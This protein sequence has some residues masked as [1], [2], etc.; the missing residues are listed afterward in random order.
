MNLSLKNYPKYN[1]SIVFLPIVF[2]VV[3]TILFIPLYVAVFKSQTKKKLLFLAL[4]DQ[5]MSL[6]KTTS[7]VDLIT[8]YT[9]NSISGSF[10]V[11]ATIPN[12]LKF[13]VLNA[14]NQDITIGYTLSND[15][16]KPSIIHF[17]NTANNNIKLQ[18]TNTS[19]DNNVTRIEINY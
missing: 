19:D 1:E 9:S 5:E 18:Y 11:T 12:S 6:S 15:I 4:E 16:T 17:N 3:L 14:D 8:F 7:F 10:E 13:K 2:F